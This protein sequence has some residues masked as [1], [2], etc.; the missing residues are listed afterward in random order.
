MDL[1][2]LATT[3]REVWTA[4]KTVLRMMTA[5]MEKLNQ[6]D[7]TRSKANL[8]KRLPLAAINSRSSSLQHINS[9]SHR[10]IIF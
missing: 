4:M 9:S 10:D 3:Y 1:P 5:R 6:R 2:A 8:R 7:S